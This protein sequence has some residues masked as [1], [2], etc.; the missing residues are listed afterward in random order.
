MAS[1]ALRIGPFM[2]LTYAS[3][4]LFEDGE[5]IS[6]MKQVSVELLVAVIPYKET[7]VTPVADFA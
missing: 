6:G 3:N 2:R 5:T 1:V 4:P 7:R